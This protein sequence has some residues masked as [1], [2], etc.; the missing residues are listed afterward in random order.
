MTIVDFLFLIIIVISVI[1]SLWRGFVREVFSLGGWIISFWVATRFSGPLANFL[2][3]MIDAYSFRVILSYVILFVI[4]MLLAAAANNL[5]SQ[6]VE[7]ANLSGTDRAI[8]A[9]FGV[10]RGFVILIMLVT[11][12]GITPFPK[13]DWWQ[14]SY[15]MPSVQS[16]AVWV[17]ETFLP[18]GY[19]SRF[20]Y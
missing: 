12:G 4:S 10:F 2:E 6:L 16:S 14:E 5:L 1:I 9:I 11:I 7:R 3:G 19:A 15:M 18:R 17:Q 13:D 20:V 8:G